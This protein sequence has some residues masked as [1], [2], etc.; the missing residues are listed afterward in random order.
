VSG[1]LKAC[2]ICKRDR[3]IRCFTHLRDVN[4]C[5]ACDA[6][7]EVDD[8]SERERRAAAWAA[9]SSAL[10]LSLTAWRAP[11]LSASNGGAGMCRSCGKSTASLA[12]E[13]CPDCERDHVLVSAMG[14]H[15][16]DADAG[17]EMADLINRASKR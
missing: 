17:A 15:S 14:P 2:R 13:T 10:Q 6:L 5:S 3:L 1:T 16:I 7:R 8:E 11:A 4:V 9:G 12:V